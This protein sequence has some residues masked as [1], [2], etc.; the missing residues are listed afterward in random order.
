MR[1]TLAKAIRRDLKANGVNIVTAEGKR[2]YKYAKR[3]A[4]SKVK[5]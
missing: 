3:L 1:Q 5:A 2:L 4:N